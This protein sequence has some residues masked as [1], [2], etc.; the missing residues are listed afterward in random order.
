[1]C[2]LN[3]IISKHK[4]EQSRH[5]Y[6]AWLQNEVRIGYWTPEEGFT[7]E[8]DTIMWDRLLNM[9]IFNAKEELHI[10]KYQGIYE[11]RLKD[12][13]GTDETYIQTPFLWG[14][15]LMGANTIVEPN[16]GMRLVLPFKVEKTQLPLRYK[17]INY[18]EFDSTHGHIHFTDARL[19][20]FLDC[21]GN[22]LE[23]ING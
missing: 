14:L 23:E 17:V 12:D 2:A 20:A 8:G 16:R 10:F 15:E 21:N 3:S 22:N 18:Y 19:S 11:S 13:S 1:M 9:R 7:D 5:Y 4:M 6:I